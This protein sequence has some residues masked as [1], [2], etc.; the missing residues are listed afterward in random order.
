L[1]EGDS[2]VQNLLDDGYNVTR[3]VPTIKTVLDGEGNVVTKATNATV[4]LEKEDSGCAII[5]VDL[6][7][8]KV[9]QITIFTR[10]VIEKP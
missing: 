2:D 4:L 7:A 6:E 3:V 5:S 8:N 9:T 1:V 10:T